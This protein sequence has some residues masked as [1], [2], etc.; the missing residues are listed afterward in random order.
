MADNVTIDPGANAFSEAT[1]DIGG[2]HFPRI[3]LI[4]GDD[5][6][7]D[8]D[9]SET[10]PLPVSM[11]NDGSAGIVALNN[12]ASRLLTIVGAVDTDSTPVRMYT[13]P[14][15]V[16]PTLTSAK[17]DISSSGDNEI[18]AASASLVTW[19]YRIFLVAAGDVTIKFRDG[20]T[21]LTGAMTLKAGGSIT[22][23]LD[24]E[25]W[26]T[27]ST[28]TAFQINLSAAVQVSGRIY[29]LRDAP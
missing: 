2:V 23:D 1:D 5:G 11:P 25:P 15:P 12:S 16:Q 9:V 27:T 20:T 28:N 26:F 8:G 29:Y 18:V 4:H 3:K 14:A 17:I 19:V 24:G 10:N 22:L 13:G 21:D 6:T 7:N